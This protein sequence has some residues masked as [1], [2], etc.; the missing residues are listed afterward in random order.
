MR[1]DIEHSQ[2]SSQEILDQDKYGRQLQTQADDANQKMSLLNGEVFFTEVLSQLLEKICSIRQVLAV[3]E[4]AVLDDRFEEAV[5]LLC[6]ADDKLIALQECQNARV[7]GLL[8][9]DV[10]AVR[11]NL[12][13]KLAGC[14]ESA[15]CID[16][17]NSAIYIKSHVQRKHI[18]FSLLLLLISCKGHSWLIS[19]L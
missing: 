14:W 10:S 17:S 4:E 8:Q 18:I 11:Q 19:I 9:N 16:F 7:A 5:D 1:A 15:F 13:E 6:K 3:T 2:K 12:V